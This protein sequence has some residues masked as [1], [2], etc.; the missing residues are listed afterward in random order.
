MTDNAICLLKRYCHAGDHLKGEW[1]YGT[2]IT[3]EAAHCCA[4]T[5]WHNR[6]FLV[7]AHCTELPP[8]H[9]LGRSTAV[10]R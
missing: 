4:A 8:M 9:S 2:T 6:L 1:H 3:L 10:F 5:P 7:I